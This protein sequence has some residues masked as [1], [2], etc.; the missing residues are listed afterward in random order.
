MQS[1]S[2]KNN[3]YGIR[4]SKNVNTVHTYNLNTA[5]DQY[6]VELPSEVYSQ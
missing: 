1:R 2:P 4:N 5:L 3:V 6:K